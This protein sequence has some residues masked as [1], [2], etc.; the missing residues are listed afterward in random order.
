MRRDAMDGEGGTGG[1]ADTRDLVWVGAVAVNA[2]GLL[3]RPRQV[4][5]IELEE[6]KEVG[7]VFRDAETGTAWV[8]SIVCTMLPSGPG[9]VQQGR[10]STKHFRL[11]L[12]I[13][14]IH[15]LERHTTPSL[16]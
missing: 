1:L 8:S 11:T 16:S 5:T 14:P 7:I 6:N 2:A 12:L 9:D 4:L 15:H 13:R 10:A 3:P